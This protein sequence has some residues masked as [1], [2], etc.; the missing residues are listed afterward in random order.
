MSKLK[1]CSTYKNKDIIYN[2]QTK[3]SLFLKQWKTWEM[4]ERAGEVEQTDTP[5]VWCVYSQCVTAPGHRNIWTVLLSSHIR[6][7]KDRPLTLHQFMSCRTKLLYRKRAFTSS[8]W[9]CRC[10]AL[11]LTDAANSVSTRTEPAE[12]NLEKGPAFTLQNKLT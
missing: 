9:S 4:K 12:Q 6:G 11:H 5:G 8:E 1:K 10:V 3:T 7:R 2:N